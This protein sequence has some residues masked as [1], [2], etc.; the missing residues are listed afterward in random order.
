MPTRTRAANNRQNPHTKLVSTPHL[1][2]GHVDNQQTQTDDERERERQQNR[3][4]RESGNAHNESTQ[5]SNPTP[6][7]FTT[8]L[9]T[10]DR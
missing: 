7:Q 5:V 6:C 8:T 4:R 10:H 1:S 3:G 9:T 2:R